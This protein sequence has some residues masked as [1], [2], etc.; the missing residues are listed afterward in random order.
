M[1]E[2]RVEDRVQVI[3]DLYGVI[4]G[5]DRGYAWIHYDHGGYVTTATIT[6]SPAPPD[7]ARLSTGEP[8]GSPQVS[9]PDTVTITISREDANLLADY[10]ELDYPEMTR[11]ARAARAALEG[12]P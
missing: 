3:G 9:Q 1:S 12:T 6:L 10:M 8:S 2:F 11:I 5:F 4:K 7:T